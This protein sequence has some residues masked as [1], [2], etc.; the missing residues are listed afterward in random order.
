MDSLRAEDVVG[1]EWAAWYL[2]TPLERWEESMKLWEA[3]VA[4]GGTMDPDPDSQSPFYDEAEWREF[5]D[6]RPFVRVGR[7]P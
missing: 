7:L 4:L 1:K 2:M 6:G 5:S 3:Y